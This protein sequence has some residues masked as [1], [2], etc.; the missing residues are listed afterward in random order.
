MDEGRKTWRRKGRKPHW[1]GG[2]GTG[3][4]GDGGGQEGGK[5]QMMDAKG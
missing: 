3:R 4:G 2:D 1:G 5:E